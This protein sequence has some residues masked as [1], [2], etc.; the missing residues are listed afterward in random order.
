[1]AQLDLR[2]SR[3]FLLRLG[4]REGLERRLLG[5][6][7][8]AEFLLEAGLVSFQLEVDYC[9]VGRV[10]A[11]SGDTGGSERGRSG[12]VCGGGVGRGVVGEGGRGK[13][14]LG[15]LFSGHGGEVVRGEVGSK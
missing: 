7:P 12:A 9:S 10:A 8:L 4:L 6:L 3:S 13:G 2:P 5:A 1:L 15:A 14:G 11:C